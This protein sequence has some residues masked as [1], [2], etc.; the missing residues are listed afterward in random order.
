MID[1]SVAGAKTK[2]KSVRAA[3][4]GAETKPAGRREENHV[5]AAGKEARRIKLDEERR[6]RVV[7]DAELRAVEARAVYEA[8][9]EHERTR[10]GQRRLQEAGIAWVMGYDTPAANLFGKYVAGVT[11]AIKEQA[12]RKQ[13][14]GDPLNITGHSQ[15]LS[16]KQERRQAEAD[17]LARGDRVVT[18]P[19]PD[20]P[21]QNVMVTMRSHSLRRVKLQ[22]HQ[23]PGAERFLRDWEAANYAGLSSMGFDP[24][25][26]SSPKPSTEH[27]AAEADAR[28]KMAMKEIGRRNWDICVGVLILNLNPT[29]IHALGGRDH[30]SVSHDI[31]V[32]M[33]ALAAFYDPVRLNRD[34]TWKAFRKIFET[35]AIVIESGQ[36]EVR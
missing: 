28:L 31:D 7:R 30:R 23:E 4:A 24:R 18:I 26:D 21:M 35:G 14:A 1:I 9:M 15:K 27:R 36:K 25:V 12:R 20:Q 5:A 34:P 17:R 19:D 13:A 2:A 6:Q 3:K 8:R 29:K 16:E 22:I 33:N 10:E 11:R 32:A